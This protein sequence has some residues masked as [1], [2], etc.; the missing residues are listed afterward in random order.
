MI[1]FATESDRAGV[2]TLLEE[3]FTRDREYLDHFLAPST[4]R[5]LFCRVEQGRVVSTLSA[6]Q[7]SYVSGEEVTS[8]GAGFH[9]YYQGFYLYGLCTAADCRGR[10]YAGSLIEFAAETARREGW[11]FLILR[12]M[13]SDSRL[14]EYYRRRG[15]TLET[16]RRSGL[17]TC[18]EPCEI[19]AMRASQLFMLR[20]KALACNYFQW[21][22]PMLHY[23]IREARL[24]PART[25]AVPPEPWAL[26]R[27]LNADFRLSGPDAVFSYPMD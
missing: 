8:G 22:A 11:D 21:S 25:P 20:H 12:P 4:D 27:P 18:E 5:R 14:A 13:D 7:I 1:R 23:I 26:V 6:F 16:F 2:R 19:V 9:K 10:G 24:N 3:N 15:F 17:P